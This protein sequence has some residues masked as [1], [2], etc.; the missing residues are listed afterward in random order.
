MVREERR[1]GT[2]ATRTHGESESRDESTDETTPH[3]LV[4]EVVTHFL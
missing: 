3:R 2:L 4:G 1:N